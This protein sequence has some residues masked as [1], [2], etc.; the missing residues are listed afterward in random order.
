MPG[1]VAQRPRGFVTQS[2]LQFAKA[3][4]AHPAELSII[5]VRAGGSAENDVS[6]FDQLLAQFLHGCD[7][8]IALDRP[9]LSSFPWILGAP[10]S[11]FSKLILRISPCTSLP[12]RGRP[13]SGRDFRRQY[14]AKS[15]RILTGY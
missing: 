4:V 14:A 3:Q 9:S 13:P 7:L 1:D 10:H 12:I 5:S 8:V 6:G 11:G 2:G 15:I